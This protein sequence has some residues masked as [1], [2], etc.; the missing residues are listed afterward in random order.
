M[1]YT[2]YALYNIR[3]DVR[4]IRYVRIAYTYKAYRLYSYYIG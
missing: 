1:R 2:V 4:Y 3:Y